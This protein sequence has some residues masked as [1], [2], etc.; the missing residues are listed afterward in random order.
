MS[1]TT[2]FKNPSGNDLGSIFMHSSGLGY[3]TGYRDINGTNFSQL[4]M[5]LGLY[6]PYPYQTNYKISNGND[7]NTIFAS[8]NQPVPFAAT[9]TYT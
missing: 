1:I 2:N 5:P 4:F 3:D 9:G 6:S 8:A 7:L